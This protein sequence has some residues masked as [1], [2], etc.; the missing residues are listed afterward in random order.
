MLKGW[1]TY[2]TGVGALIGVA[3]GAATGALPVAEAINIG[4]TALLAMFIRSGVATD[5]KAN[6]P[7]A[8]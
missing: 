7:L 6:N 4:V 3:I 8:K 1:K 2:L 5:A